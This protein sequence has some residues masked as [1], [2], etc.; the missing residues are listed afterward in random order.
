MPLT[1]RINTPRSG[2][3]PLT[4]VWTETGW[5]LDFIH[6]KRDTQPDGTSPGVRGGLSGLLSNEMAEM[7]TTVARVFLCLWEQ[8]RDDRVTP[9]GA[10]ARFEALGEWINATT[11]ACPGDHRLYYEG[12]IDG[13]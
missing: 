13:Q 3:L 6:H 7:P 8:T 11:A 4:A 1:T 2:E 12:E 5:H 10:Q 9:Q